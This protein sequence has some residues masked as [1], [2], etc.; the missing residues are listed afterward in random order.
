MKNK[1]I[2]FTYVSIKLGWKECD[3]DLDIKSFN[4]KL[5]QKKVNFL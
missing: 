2:F 1:N 4:L 5:P 3:K